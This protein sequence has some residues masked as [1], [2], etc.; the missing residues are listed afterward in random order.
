MLKKKRITL[1]ERILNLLIF[2]EQI[3]SPIY[4]ECIFAKTDD[5][6]HRVGEG[7]IEKTT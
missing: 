5:D 7:K 1:L 3:F 4:N 2:F 6:S